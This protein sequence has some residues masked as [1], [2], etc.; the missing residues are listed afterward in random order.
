MGEPAGLVPATITVGGMGKQPR[1]ATLAATG[2]LVSRGAGI[3]TAGGS[4]ALGLIALTW[5]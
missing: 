2:V 4:A 5:P 1:F 3:G